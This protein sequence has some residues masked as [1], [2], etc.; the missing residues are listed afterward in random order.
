VSD[1]PRLLLLSQRGLAPHIS[2]CCSYEFEDLIQSVDAAD[3]IAPLYRLDGFEL[4][5]RAVNK[6]GRRA[7][8]LKGINPGIRP[9]RVERHY[10][11]FFA[12]F[13]FATDAISLNALRNW[14]DNCEVAAC[15]LE[16]IWA[17]D[18]IRLQSQIGLLRQFDL[19]FTNCL[20]SLDGLV[21]ATGQRVVYQPPGVDCLNFFP[22]DP[23]PQR[24]IDIFNMGRR[25]PETHQALLRVAEERG[26][27]YLYDTFKGN[28]PVRNPS[29]HRQQL[30]N[31]VKRTRF[32]MANKAK[33]NEEG[34]TARQEEVGF[35]FFEG[36]AGGAVMIGDPPD[37]ASFRK[38]FDW[39]DAV[40]RLPFG[41]RDVCNLIAD[42]EKQP[43]R[44][45][46]IRAANM[47]NSLLR[48]DWAYRWRAVLD[49]TGMDQLP[50]L[51]ARLALLS[52]HANQ[53]LPAYAGE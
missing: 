31:L 15:W 49:L 44:L 9:V 51:Q 34:E 16:E 21:K 23:P 22:G 26:L 6:L 27:F 2:R 14:R 48:H 24:V 30:A 39:P 8:L 45:A 42:L 29:E 41:S 47:W 35:R 32:F 50:S 33:V 53:L 7:G 38:H 40:V 36:A 52:A 18:L 43:E 19:I 4:L 10:Q 3:L 28:V 11:L 25:H 17:K 37:V 5:G 13:Q 1:Q 46:R 12:V 20:S